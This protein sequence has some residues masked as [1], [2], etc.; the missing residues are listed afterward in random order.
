MAQVDAVVNCVSGDDDTIARAAA[1]VF[2]A[3]AARPVRVLHLSSMAVYGSAIGRVDEDTPLRTDIGAYGA[4]KVAAE[5]S[6]AAARDCIVLRPGCVYGGGSPQWTGRIAR[7]LVRRRLGD[8]G[9]AGD[10]YANLVQLRD[11]LA[12]ILAA[13]RLPGD[14]VRAFNLALA[15][16]PDWNA[17]LVAFGRALGAVPVRRI[18]GW[19]LALE[20]K[21]PP[22]PL[23]V[24]GRVLGRSR[25]P[26]PIPRR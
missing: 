24:A 20:T 21:A 8:L 1:A 13:L 2:A 6:A 26:D 11:V 15:G 5:R 10:G 17:Y 4:A 22:P 25:V 3:A 16:G 18:P 9:A 23:A 19:E 7:M 12:A 14:G